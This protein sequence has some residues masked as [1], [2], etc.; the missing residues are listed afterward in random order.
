MP[1][2]FGWPKLTPPTKE[3]LADCVAFYVDGGVLGKNPSPIGVYWSVYLDHPPEKPRGIVVNRRES[4][5]HTTNNEAEWMA[6]REALLYAGRHFPGRNLVI[7][8]DSKLIVLQFCGQYRN[9]VERLHR[10]MSEVRA[11]ATYFPKVHVLWKSRWEMV[12][13]LGH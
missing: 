13:R 8:S 10:M 7:Y 12:R 11:L 1:A 3:E 4:R 5:E 9:K 6:V 2:D